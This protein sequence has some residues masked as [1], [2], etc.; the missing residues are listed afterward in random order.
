MRKTTLLATSIL[1][2]QFLA[3][4]SSESAIKLT[5]KYSTPITG[6]YGPE[7]LS[8]CL[9]GSK[10]TTGNK[11]KAAVIL[12]KP[13]TKAAFTA[14][15]KKQDESYLGSRI[16]VTSASGSTA[17]LGNLTSVVATNIRWDVQID[18]TLDWLGDGEYPYESEEEDPSYIEDGYEYVYFTA[19]CL[20]SGTV[21]LVKS[22]AYTIF[23]A[24]YKGPEYS[25]AE[26]VKKKWTVVLVDN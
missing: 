20:Y 19:D 23:I 12:K 3:L 4:P 26:L 6:D 18:N 24:G 9:V 2:L 8:T 10:C 13:T 5:V 16:K 14:G 21:T 11:M 1:L 22:N 25:Y 17:G 7:S 15:C